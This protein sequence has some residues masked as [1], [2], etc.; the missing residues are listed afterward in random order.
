MNKMKHLKI[1]E[2]I[3]NLESTEP[4]LTMDTEGNPELLKFVNNKPPLMKGTWK[5]VS[6][7]GERMHVFILSSGKVNVSILASVSDI[8]GDFP[9]SGIFEIERNSKVGQSFGGYTCSL[10]K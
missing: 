7:E 1:Y 2:E 10:Y 6:L 8:S 3:S 4:L 5:K 9:M